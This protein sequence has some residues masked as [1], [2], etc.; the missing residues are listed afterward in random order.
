MQ[1][2]FKK[3]FFLVIPLLSL[4]LFAP[5]AFAK[6]HK[7]KHKHCHP[8]SDQSYYDQSYYDDSYYD[9]GQ[10]YDRGR[11]YDEDYYR[12]PRYRPQYDNGYSDRP[13]YGAPTGNYPWWDV[14][15]PRY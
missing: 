3:L 1:T 15:I 7:Y 8:R 5:S 10:R 12:R 13:Y 11:Y 14:L 9:R 4:V 6:R 2:R